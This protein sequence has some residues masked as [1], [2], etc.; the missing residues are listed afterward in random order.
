MSIERGNQ[1]HTQMYS[2]RAR[3]SCC[4]FRAKREHLRVRKMQHMR[5]IHTRIL[6][7]CL[8]LCLQL[9]DRTRAFVY[10]E[11]VP[12]ACPPDR[13]REG[14]GIE[15]TQSRTS[16]SHSD[17]HSRCLLFLLQL[18]DRTRAFA[19]TEEGCPG[20]VCP[21]GEGKDSKDWACT[22]C[23]A[24]PEPQRLAECLE[25]ERMCTVYQR[26]V[27]VLEDRGR[28]ERVREAAGRGGGNVTV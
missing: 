10:G 4:R 22:E 13:R 21:T 7:R 9:P 12:R 14:K 18:P 23:G 27:S 16:H 26:G 25:Q 17:T 19:C 1:T 2:L 6:S 20:P 28:R 3:F 15:I 5:R 11:R 8:Y 24:S